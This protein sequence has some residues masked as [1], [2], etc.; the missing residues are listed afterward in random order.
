MCKVQFWVHGELF[1][2][3][4]HHSAGGAKEDFQEEETLKI[5]FHFL[6]MR[7]EIGIP[8]CCARGVC[9]CVTP[10]SL[11]FLAHRSGPLAGKSSYQ[12]FV[13][14]PRHALQGSRA[15]RMGSA[16]PLDSAVPGLGALL[17]GLPLLAVTVS[18][19]PEKLLDCRRAG[20][21]G[22][23]WFHLEGLALAEAWPILE[24]PPVSSTHTSGF[25]DPEPVC[26]SEQGLLD[27]SS[28]CS[29]CGWLLPSQEAP[30]NGE[31][32]GAGTGTVRQF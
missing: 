32:G 3:P 24:L 1:A 9:V 31:E 13:R 6:G 2:V 17:L 29:L 16:S 7:S 15:T 30:G 14:S 18:L 19:A 21:G 20:W 23:A 11:R 25:T 5:E 12:G 10:L 8:G 27:F 26:H 28:L 22:E 4:P